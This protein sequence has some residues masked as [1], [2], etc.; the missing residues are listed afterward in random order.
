MKTYVDATVSTLND[1][2]NLKLNAANILNYYNKTETDAL[3]S[4]LIGSAGESLDTLKEL[5]DAL[6][7]D[8][9]PQ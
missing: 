4:N 5:A 7:N 1:N 3:F 9:P 8:R 2:I 6:N